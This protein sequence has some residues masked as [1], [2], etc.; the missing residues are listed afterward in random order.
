MHSLNTYRLYELG[1][2]LHSLFSAA[3]QERVAD[4][5]VPLTEAQT[6]LDSAI[7]GEYI[8]LET[9]KADATQH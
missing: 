9:S 2:K 4:M 6:L 7:K 1:A 3:P 5:F 8:T